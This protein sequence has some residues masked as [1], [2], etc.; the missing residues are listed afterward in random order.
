MG[1]FD[2]FKN[3]SGMNSNY[4]CSK[5]GFDFNYLSDNYT[6]IRN[7]KYWNKE[8]VNNCLKILK[9]C[10]KLINTTKKAD[11]FFERYLLALSILNELI[12]IENKLSFK[13]D[14]PS[15]I[16][17]QLYEKEIFTV[18]DFL[19]RYYNDF[20]EKINQLKTT[21][22][23]KNKI[24]AF[25]NELKDYMQYLSS[26]SIEKYNNLYSKLNELIND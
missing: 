12:P 1:M 21:K 20:F 7:N 4:N 26:E 2:I 23:K 3:L 19:D 16:K 9:D 10:A 24:D 25:S 14:K 13:G 8:T 11:I 17:K 22:A 18:N 6:Y 5:K 15:K